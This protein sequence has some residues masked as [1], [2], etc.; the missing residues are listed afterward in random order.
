[1][2]APNNISPST[3]TSDKFVEYYAS[4]SLSDETLERFKGIKRAVE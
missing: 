3:A 4:E 2:N 1:M